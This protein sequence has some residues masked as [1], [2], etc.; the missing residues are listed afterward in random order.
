MRSITPPATRGKRNTGFQE[1]LPEQVDIVEVT[2]A[3]WR[4]FRRHLLRW[5][6]QQ[7]RA[8]EIRGREVCQW[9]LWGL[10]L[11]AILKHYVFVSAKKG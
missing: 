11:T 5:V 8:R 3:C 1:H 10:A 9:V 2:D 4:G 6:Y 7:G